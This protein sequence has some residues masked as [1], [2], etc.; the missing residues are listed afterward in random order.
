MVEL[1]ELTEFRFYKL[2]PQY[3]QRCTNLVSDIYAEQAGNNLERECG[4]LLW[5]N[6]KASS[7]VLKCK[8]VGCFAEYDIPRICNSCGLVT[9]FN[10]VTCNNCE[11]IVIN[12]A[13]W[14]VSIAEGE[15]A[16]KKIN[17]AFKQN[18]IPEDEWRNAIKIQSE[19]IE[20]CQK[21]LEKLD[22]N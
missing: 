18:L 3:Q 4:G 9:E 6:M 17:R 16:I 15:K 19:E 11:P 5:L 21:S 14:K 13:T 10:D 8:H 20:K 7:V 12:I 22:F 2:E 1:E